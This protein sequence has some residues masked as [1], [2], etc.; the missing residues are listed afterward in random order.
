MSEAQKWCPRGQGS[1]G[2]TEV[3]VPQGLRA[4][5]AHGLLLS[6]GGWARDAGSLQARPAARGEG[7]C[8]VSCSPAGLL[9]VLPGRRGRRP[10]RVFPQLVPGPQP[11]VRPDRQGQHGLR[12]QGPLSAMFSVRSFRGENSDS[13]RGW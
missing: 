13:G 8:L 10:G 3:G 7:R 2:D 9:P 5:A 1:P 6:R 12:A 11:G 4:L